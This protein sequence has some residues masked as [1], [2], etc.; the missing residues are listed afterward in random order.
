MVVD[1]T[2]L[3]SLAKSIS[4]HFLCVRRVVRIAVMLRLHAIAEVVSCTG[5]LLKYDHLV[6]STCIEFIV[7]LNLYK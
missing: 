6:L 3:E 7:E 5:E 1:S 4:S 2:Y